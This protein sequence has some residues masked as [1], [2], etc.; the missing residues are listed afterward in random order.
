MAPDTVLAPARPAPG[1]QL[2]IVLEPVGQPELKTIHI[3]DLL[4]AVGRTE[5]PFAS[6][7]PELAS[8]LSRRHARIFCE[9]GAVYLA[10]LGSKNG[11]TVNGTPV[12]QAIVKLKSG[13][14][15]GLGKALSYR[16]QLE[17]AAVQ[18][19]RTRLISLTLTPQQEGKDLQAIVISDFPFMISKAD[20][21]FARYK[22]SDPAQVHY[23]SRRH[24]HIFLKGGEPYVEDL[25]STNG[26]FVG[27]ERLEEHAVALHEGDVL[28][29]GGHHFVYEVSMEWETLP[30][31]PTLTQ[32]GVPLTTRRMQGGDDDKTTFVAAADSFLNIFCVDAPAAKDPA[33][34]ADDAAG[35]A[36][37]A[38]AA[39]PQGKAAVMLSGF[40]QA[41]GGKGDLDMTRARNMAIAALAVVIL[42]AWA[43]SHLGGAEREAANLIAS[44]N[45]AQ[46]ASVAN[47]ALADAPDDRKL[48]ALA[49]EA[50]LKASLPGWITSM[51]ARQYQTATAQVATMRQQ[52]R[53]NPDM[54]PLLAELDWIIQLESFVASRGGAQAPVHDAADGAKI[55]QFLKQ[56]E[57]QNEAHQRAF[58]TMSSFVPEFRDA[59]A[60]ALSD[61]RKL[62]LAG[63][64]PGH[65]PTS[66]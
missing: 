29:F 38:E 7:P 13:D 16:V 15:L 34:D 61:A 64:E 5:E 62:A 54:T 18:P 26:T 47:A 30:P 59:Y 36:P 2:M 40:Y 4:F 50:Q 12:R 24:A 56:W 35:G 17:S 25:G 11:T 46:A 60:A 20:D 48:R 3:H 55:K 27:G 10:D 52:A 66:P 32:L 45:Y 65:E 42:L 33:A 41:L 22:D 14:V 21:T 23:L 63:G 53:N 43:L 49:L 37:Q 1:R 6:Y 28:A 51:K 57:E 8:S 19:Q 9:H 31:D 44:G 58:V 39:Q